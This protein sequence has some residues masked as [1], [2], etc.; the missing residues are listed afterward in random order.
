MSAMAVAPA[1]QAGFSGLASE[2]VVLLATSDSLGV[3]DTGE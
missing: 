3:F 1:A 2:D